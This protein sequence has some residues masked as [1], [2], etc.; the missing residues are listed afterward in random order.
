[1]IRNVLY[2]EP[3]SIVVQ[4]SW[5]DSDIVPGTMNVIIGQGTCQLATVKCLLIVMLA[6]F[7]PALAGAEGTLALPVSASSA[8][9]VR[10]ATAIAWN[11][12]LSGTCE[13]VAMRVPH[14]LQRVSR[15]ERGA[16]SRRDLPIC[17]CE[18]RYV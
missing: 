7:A 13:G 9:L 1:V 4:G 5:D 17:R 11:D 14:D 16:R 10:S 12:E 18:T 8:G 2:L 6:L 15:R 3:Y